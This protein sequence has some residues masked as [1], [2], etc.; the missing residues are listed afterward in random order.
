MVSLRKKRGN[1]YLN[2]DLTDIN[3]EMF[4]NMQSLEWN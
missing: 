4:K 3:N 2:I 1:K